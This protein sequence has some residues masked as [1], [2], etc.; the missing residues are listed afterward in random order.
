[1]NEELLESANLYALGLLTGDAQA[2]FERELRTNAPL[3]EEVHGLQEAAL[4][5]ARSAPQVAPPAE[6]RDQLL[7]QF[8]AAAPVENLVALSS[9]QSPVSAPAPALV[10]SP[11]PVPAPAKATRDSGSGRTAA[12]APP[13]SAAKLLH[14]IPWAAAAAM[15]FFFHQNKQAVDR[16]RTEAGTAR[17]EAASVKEREKHYLEA[18]SVSE[19]AKARG[20]AALAELRGNLAKAEAA[21]SLLDKERDNLMAE[22]T[23]LRKDSELDKTHIAVLGSLL[24]NSPQAVAV[25]LWRQERQE[26]LLVV[27][28]M[29][30]LPPGRDYQL[31]VI[32]PNQKIP[33]SAGVFKVDAEGK[34]RL[35]FKPA[36]NVQ[37]AY[38]FAVTVEKE[39]GA[40]VPTLDQMVVIGG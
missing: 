11:A 36:H 5:L 14:F 16:A 15:A 13:Q 23:L 3:Q 12:S 33:V 17:A 7:A 35:E 20:D 37:S 18:V 8:M 29:P 9:N 39:G 24:K 6:L 21:L 32:D 27:E 31:W 1:M 34:V 26:G 2:A 38:K 10:L 4:L 40:M 19:A 28:N 25:S 22:L 30:A